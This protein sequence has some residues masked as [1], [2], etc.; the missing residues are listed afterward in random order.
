[1]G[2]GPGGFTGLRVACGVAQGIAF[3]LE[4]PVV[5]VVSLMAVAQRDLAAAPKGLGSAFR[6][7]VQDARMNEIYLAAYMPEEDGTW[8]T[9]QA[10]MLLAASDL[11]LW[12]DQSIRNAPG[13]LSADRPI[14]LVGDGLH[15]CT[16]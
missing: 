2:Q 11:T 14:R 4:I 10:P 8:H 13:G 1:F 15:L 16:G 5:P 3:A 9:V 12:L 7:V 6:V